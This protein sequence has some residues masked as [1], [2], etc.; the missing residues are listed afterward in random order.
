MR[1]AREQ[2][3]GNCLRLP[4]PR[5]FARQDLRIAKLWL[6]DAEFS[7][8]EQPETSACLQPSWPARRDAEGCAEARAGT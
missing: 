4:W 7:V 6:A 1:N 5:D 2:S 8:L 3:D